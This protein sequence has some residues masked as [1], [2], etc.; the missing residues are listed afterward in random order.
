M[1]RIHG[2]KRNDNCNEELHNLYRLHIIIM[3]KFK[4]MQQ[5]QYMIYL[6]ENKKCIHNFG[7]KT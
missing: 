2:H 5:I 6:K 7:Q 1:L 3:I 4:R